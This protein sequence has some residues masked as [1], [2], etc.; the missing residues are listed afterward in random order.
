MATLSCTE[1]SIFND[2][3][4]FI[5]K[6]ENNKAFGSYS[7]VKTFNIESGNIAECLEHCL[8]DCQCQSFQI[9]QN[10]KCQLC[11]SHKE[12][13]SSLLH[14]KGSCVY[15]TYKMQQSTTT[16]Q[17]ICRIF[18]VF[19]CIPNVIR[20]FLDIHEKLVQSSFVLLQEF[21]KK[22]SDIS[23]S[24]KYN[25]CQQPGLCPKNKVCKPFN[26]RTKSWKRFTCECR[27][28][29][30]V[31]NCDQPIKSCQGY[32]KGLQ[33]S[34]LYK[35]KS[36]DGTVYKVYCHFDSEL[37][38]TLVQSY[39]FANKSLRWL[40]KPLFKDLPINEKYPTWSSYRLSKPR[41]RSIRDNSTY[42]MFTC[43]YE[44]TNLDLKTSD[45]LQISLQNINKISKNIDIIEFREGFTS[46]IR[47]AK[48]RGKM[49]EHDLT[50]CQVWFY[51]GY[52]NPLHVHISKQIPEFDP[53]DDYSNRVHFFNIFTSS[54]GCLKK[55]HRCVQNDN[56][57]TQLW[58]G[59]LKVNTAQASVGNAGSVFGSV[60]A[61]ENIG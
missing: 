30:Y 36:S 21:D 50:E 16:F 11:A 44:K 33:K 7:L 48:G 43:D 56:S 23:C 13:N 41:M 4:K 59:A 39:S 24:M 57:T 32:A 35:L 51:Q 14:E 1:S 60:D 6:A 40:K 12:A 61:F 53:C 37:A 45:Y 26:S 55:I 18:E 2:Q 3:P 28:G 38:W 27:D 10:T 54:Y 15:V 8:Q 22:C 52:N 49:G 20:K 42:L 25:C 58:F 5:L 17:V 31:E 29:Y 19:Y 9:C 34:G 47:V 46:G